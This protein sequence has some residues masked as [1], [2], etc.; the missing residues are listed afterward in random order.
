MDGPWWMAVACMACANA[1]IAVM[2][3]D[4]P[5]AA[6][7]WPAVTAVVHLLATGARLLAPSDDGW[8]RCAK[9]FVWVAWVWALYGVVMLLVCEYPV[10]YY[11]VVG[12]S[13]VLQCC[14]TASDPET[15]TH[16]QTIAHINTNSAA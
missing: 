5:C 11:V 12:A 7:V 8:H 10:P 6:P 16:A 14:S 13:A 2:Y 15:A 4:E 9:H 3:W 1:V